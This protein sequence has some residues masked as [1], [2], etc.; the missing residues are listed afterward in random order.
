MKYTKFSESK[1]P[2]KHCPNPK[3]IVHRC[4]KCKMKN[5][6]LTRNCPKTKKEQFIKNIR[7]IINDKNKKNLGK[8]E[9]E[10]IANGFEDYITV[11]WLDN[12]DF[13]G[14]PKSFKY[15]QNIQKQN[16][17]NYGPLIRFANNNHELLQ[18]KKWKIFLKVLINKY[19]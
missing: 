7:K 17:R 15:F 4:R 5:D 1:C 11:G 13:I 19:S 18:N 3:C 10:R 12:N 9:I 8:K 2:I 16:F 14:D 6:H